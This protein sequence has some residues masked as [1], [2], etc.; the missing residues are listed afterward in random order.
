MIVFFISVAFISNVC[1]VNESKVI[2]N[3]VLE[4]LT[5][6]FIVVDYCCTKCF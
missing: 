6:P 5:L 3:A 2:K 4:L 1:A